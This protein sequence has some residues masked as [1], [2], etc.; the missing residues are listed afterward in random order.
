M[1]NNKFKPT[2][3]IDNYYITK[4]LLIRKT[5][6]YQ[7]CGDTSI[8]TVSHARNLPE[9][10][11]WH[12]WEDGSGGLVAPDGSNIMIYDDLTKLRQEFPHLYRWR[13]ELPFDFI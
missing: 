8:E 9:G 6:H 2:N 3:E 1:M 4:N 13:D 12:D 11:E 10:W 5:Y 7:D